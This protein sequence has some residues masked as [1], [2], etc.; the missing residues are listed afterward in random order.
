[1]CSA[2]N[3]PFQ[4]HLLSSS[5]YTSVRDNLGL[6]IYT[7]FAS[8]FFPALHLCEGTLNLTIFFSFTAFLTANTTALLSKAS[9]L[10]IN[11]FRTLPS[12]PAL[13]LLEQTLCENLIQKVKFNVLKFRLYNTKSSTM[14]YLKKI[15]H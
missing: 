11:G 9:Q 6:N 7:A 8:T 1:M 15:V 5:T 4:S 12:P 2:E 14:I 3:S 13:S 10:D